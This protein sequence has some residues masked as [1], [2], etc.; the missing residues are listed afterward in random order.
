MRSTYFLPTL[1]GVLGLALVSAPGL[2]HAQSQPVAAP[3]AAS[4]TTTTGTVVQQQGPGLP[5][6][7]AHQDTYSNNNR[8]VFRILGLSGQL[9]APVTPAYNAD[10]AYRTFAGQPMRGGDA[11]MAQSMDGAP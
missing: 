2:A 11:V 6:V 3:M 1:L 5:P 4:G 9:S 10:A 8:E 7:N